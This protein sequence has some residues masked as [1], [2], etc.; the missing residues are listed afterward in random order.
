ML[1]LI[2][3]R[4]PGQPVDL[5]AEPT[6]RSIILHWTPPADFNSTLVRKY[7]LKYG[8]G[9]PITEIEVP[10]SRNSFIING[11]STF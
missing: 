6:D 11:L 1:N 9:F 10:G 3:T 2:E 4:V 5:H 7:L 8:I